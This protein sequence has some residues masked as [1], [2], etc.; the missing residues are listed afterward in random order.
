MGT[1]CW[2]LVWGFR[3]VDPGIDRILWVSSLFGRHTQ[4]I[5]AEVWGDKT[6]KEQEGHQES[7]I[8]PVTTVCPEP[9]R[10][11]CLFMHT[12]LLRRGLIAA[13]VGGR[14]GRCLS[15][16]YHSFTPTIKKKKKKKA[17]CIELQVFPVSLLIMKVSVSGIQAGCWLHLW[18]GQGRTGNEWPIRKWESGGLIFWFL[19]NLPQRFQGWQGID[20]RCLTACTCYLHSRYRQ[21]NKFLAQCRRRVYKNDQSEILTGMLVNYGWSV[22]LTQK[23]SKNTILQKSIMQYSLMTCSL[24]K[25]H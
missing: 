14:G 22:W 5:L 7:M 23:Y 18:E 16:T 24:G 1:V 15:S 19:F 12:L 4:E 8:K 13:L 3:E 6:G 25:W 11:R 2:I 10:Y 20:L 9:P 17:L 21:E